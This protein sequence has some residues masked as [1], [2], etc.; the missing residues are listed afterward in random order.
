MNGPPVCPC[1][2]VLPPLPV[3]NPPGRDTLR[4]RVGDFA[5]FRRALLRPVDAAATGLPAE[6]ALAAWRPGATGDLA[7]QMVEWFA[8]LADILTF[9]NERV[10]CQAYLRTADRPES[11]NRLV[12]LLGY[13]PRPGIGAR[14][15][16]AALVSGNRAI[17]LPAGFAVQSKPG[18]GQAPQVFEL[19]A[20]TTV[21][22]PGAVAAVPAPDPALVR[23]DGSVLLRGTVTAVKAG[24]T[25]LV[26]PKQWSGDPSQG[27]LAWVTAVGPEK[28]PAGRANT[29]VALQF[30]DGGGGPAG[31]LAKDYRLLKSGQS[32]GVWQYPT[33]SVVVVDTQSVHLASL[34]RQIQA[35]DPVVIESLVPGGILGT[36][37]G[38]IIMIG[39]RRAARHRAGQRVGTITPPN[40][41]LAPG[42]LSQL[43]QA[44]GTVEVIWY[45]NPDG[46]TYDP[47]KPPAQPATPPFGP[48]PIPIPHTMLQL[49]TAIQ[50]V[51]NTDL[52]S[53]RVR[54]AW[55]DV[56]Q[57]IETA[58][59]SVPAGAGAVLKPS[60][61]A[62]F[63][64]GGGPGAT[65][66]LVEDSRG[67][68]A[69]GSVSPA[70]P[71][72]LQL[73]ATKAAL[74]PPLRALF[75]LLNVSRGQTVAGEVLGS[76]DASLAGQEFVLAKSPLTYLLTGDPNAPGSYKSTLRLRVGG[77]EW[78]EVPSFYGQAADAR[79]FVTREDNQGKTH[80]LTG[81]GVYGA[82]LPT[83]TDNVV[84]TYRFGSGAAAPA[85]GALTVILRPQPNLT[86][87][88]NPVA[89]GG[90][91][92][93]DRPDQLRRYA[94]RSVLTL[95]RAVS[96]DDYEAVAARAPGVARA[97]A[98]WAWDG[99]EQRALVKVYV[100]DDDAAVQAA[101]TALAGAADPN[102]PLRVL[103][104]AAV[105][106]RLSLTLVAAGDR[107]P[108]AVGAAARTALTDPDAGLLG[109]AAVRIG[110]GLFDSQVFAACLGVPGAVAVHGLQVFVGAGAAPDAGEPHDPG[111]GGF[112]RLAD[113]GLDLEV[114]SDAP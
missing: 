87:L 26:L 46:P 28:D 67:G 38:G 10:A 102:R 25:V 29:R 97:R 101:R 20:A 36:G 42:T 34:V 64:T 105:P 1:G 84:A 52:A 39:A 53:V 78:Q 91:A 30:Q 3:A 106:L 76:G 73:D 108:A 11:V 89:A 70:A 5:S 43:A 112:F 98:Y 93:P 19:D 85:A 113:A 104:A 86:A 96:A 61:A 2:P 14:A 103:P 47:T 23:T 110:Q 6:A 72:D 62:A 94:P 49:A 40:I 33:G 66:A 107:D 22:P 55:Q 99:D 18:P 50:P 92:D 32:V 58:K 13:R 24:D 80:V 83:G 60:G 16:L 88:R 44:Q 51:A 17:T 31:A 71:G 111:E 45:A 21:T 41:L 82:R 9:Y 109:S 95:G 65:P 59:T 54:H 114:A 15:V 79:V 90:G 35:G 100:G 27:A 81:D 68:G 57:L 74:Y 12:R 69:T 4:Y 77:V 63:P 56:G 75:N 7:V 48:P 37:G 8:Y